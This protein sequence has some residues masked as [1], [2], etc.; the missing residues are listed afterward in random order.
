M[1]Y[2]PL[3]VRLVEEDHNGDVRYGRDGTGDSLEEAGEDGEG[4]DVPLVAE[5][6]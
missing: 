2:A 6:S 4:M 5:A 3:G 1:P